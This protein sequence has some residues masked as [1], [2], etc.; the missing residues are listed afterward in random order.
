MEVR[1]MLAR[2]DM[3]YKVVEEEVP[4]MGV[5]RPGVFFSR[6]LLVQGSSCSGSSSSGV[7][8]SGVF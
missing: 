1:R 8:L 3:M 2:R 7:L 6:S 5:S 4:E